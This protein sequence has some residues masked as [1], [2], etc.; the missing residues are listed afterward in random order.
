[1]GVSHIYRV[2]LTAGLREEVQKNGDSYIK[3]SLML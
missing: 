2:C 1:M 3:I